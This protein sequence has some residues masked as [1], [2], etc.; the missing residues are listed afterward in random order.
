MEYTVNNAEQTRRLARELSGEL[1]GG[2]VIC[3]YGE[4]GA[5]KTVFAAGLCEGLG[6]TDCVS[7]PTFTIVNEHSGA[8]FPVYHFDMYRIEDEEELYEIGYEE[9]LSSGGICIIEWPENI[10]GALP[11]RR[12]DVRIE[13]R[14]SAGDE[15]RTVSIIRRSSAK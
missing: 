6:V 3:L 8:F 10:K 9:Y 14:L 4:L 12:I 7:S 2:E 5:G 13:R 15:V 1:K 11:E